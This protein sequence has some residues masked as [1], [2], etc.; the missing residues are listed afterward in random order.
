MYDNLSSL[1]AFLTA[2]DQLEGLIESVGEKYATSVSN[3]PYERWEE[4]S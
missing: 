3:D 2:L 1:D 4:K